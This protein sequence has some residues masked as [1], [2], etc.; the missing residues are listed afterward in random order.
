MSKSGR[1]E[2]QLN[3]VESI[4]SALTNT[5]QFLERNR[6]VLLL[7]V[8]AL[9]LLVVGYIAYSNLY[10]KPRELEAQKQVYFA[11]RLFGK[12]SFQVALNGDGNNLGFL[13]IMDEFSGTKIANLCRFY[14]GVCYRE[15]GD[16]DKAL[17]FLRSYSLDDDMVAPVALGAIGDCYVEKGDTENGIAFYSKAIEYRSNALSTPLFL[18]RRGLLYEAS[19]KKVEALADYQLIKDAYPRSAQASE[20]DKYIER[21]KVT[22]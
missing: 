15:L 12:D 14:T 8:V 1:T 11:E 10:A 6:K 5:E 17:E 4:E 21:V 7:G 2:E 18:L 9:V 16:Y 20:I 19:S 3:G 13:Q 22:E